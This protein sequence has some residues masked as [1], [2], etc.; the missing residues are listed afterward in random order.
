MHNTWQNESTQTSPFDL[1]MGYHPQAEWA[2]ISSPVPQVTTCLEQLQ[3]ELDKAWKAME[4]VQQRW[5][6]QK[7]KERTYQEGDYICYV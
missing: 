5:H 3:Q 2:P 6:Q 7:Q 1:L 4:Q